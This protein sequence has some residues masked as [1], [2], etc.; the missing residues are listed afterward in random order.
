MRAKLTPKNRLALPKAVLSNFEGV[1]YFDVNEENG[2]IVLTPV[3][4]APADSV[5]AE[6]AERGLSEADVTEAVVWS[7]GRMNW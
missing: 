5:R 2:R 3:Q 6:L 4:L 7:R 1:E